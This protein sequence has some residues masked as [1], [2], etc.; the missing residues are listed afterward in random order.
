MYGR[1]L[2]ANGVYSCPFLSNDYRGRVGLDFKN[3]SKNINAE[4]DF[5]A[6]CSMNNNFIFT[7]G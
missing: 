3:Y 4:S 1:V 2:G 6:T 7:I 5:C